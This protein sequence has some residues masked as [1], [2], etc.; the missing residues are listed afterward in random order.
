MVADHHHVESGVG[1]AFGVLDGL[2][3]GA[4]ENQVDT[5]T[6]GVSGHGALLRYYW[7]ST[8]TSSYIQ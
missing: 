2:G 8:S 6:S 4:R 3:D 1:G 7:W 5:E